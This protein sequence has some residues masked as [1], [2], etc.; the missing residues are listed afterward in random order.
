MAF[1]FVC[2]YWLIVPINEIILDYKP[3]FVQ[4][5]MRKCSLRSFFSLCTT[6]VYF[7]FLC[8]SIER[9]H[10]ASSY[11]LE[12]F[13]GS[14]DMN[15]LNATMFY[16]NYNIHKDR[17]HFVQRIALKYCIIGR[18]LLLF[19]PL[20]LSLVL[21][22]AHTLFAASFLFNFCDA[23]KWKWN[24]IIKAREWQRGERGDEKCAPHW[25]S[26]KWPHTH[27]LSHI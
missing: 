21:S 24:K 5:R 2:W 25:A 4:K 12:N 27:T 23:I 17:N 6:K 8:V 15:E 18:K 16:Y 10:F 1:I 13:G 14:F 19:Q 11:T 22:T 26:N 3:K 20:F 7:S 9:V